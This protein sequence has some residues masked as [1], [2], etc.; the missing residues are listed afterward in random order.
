[1]IKSYIFSIGLAF[2]L[3][4][5][6][7]AQ[8]P[9]SGNEIQN[10]EQQTKT[11]SNYAHYKPN[12]RIKKAL[13][14]FH[15]ATG[16]Y[17][18]D[19]WEIR[20]GEK[21]V[22]VFLQEPQSQIDVIA[23]TPEMTPTKLDLPA[24]YHYGAMFGTRFTTIAYW[25]EFKISGDKHEFHFVGGGD[26]LT[27]V[28]SQ[29]WLPEGKYKCKAKSVHR[30][31]LR[32]DP[33]FGYV[34]DINCTFETDK[35]VKGGIEFTNLL[36]P[37]QSNPW[38]EK[39]KY[40]YTI[41]SSADTS[42]YVRFSSNLAAG[43]LSDEIQHNWGKG[44]T[45]R[46]GGLM[47][48]V[49]KGKYSPALLRTGNAKYVQ[50]TCNVWLDQHNKALL[51]EKPDADGIYRVNPRFRFVY[52]PPQMANYLIENSV[53]FKL[54]KDS[55]VQIRLGVDEGFEEQPLS[56]STTIR[57]ICKGWWEKDFVIDQSLAHRGKKS[58]RIDG[59][60]E[61]Q[62]HQKY[63]NFIIT[64]QILLDPN[65]TYKI[66][67]YVSTSGNVKAFISADLYEWTPHDEARLKKQKT[68]MAD[69]Q[70]KWE[71]IEIVF[72]TPNYDPFVDLRFMV[73]GDGFANF[74]D[75]SFKKIQP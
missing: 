11:Q 34:F 64:P 6:V 30:A 35:F 36:T 12:F 19:F 37:A 50:N 65:S 42:G 33:V 60:T 21:I 66:E 32:I 20:D 55:M 41:Y 51:P 67:A 62:S 14:K 23:P 40:D 49:D 71:K 28:E 8:N 38:P 15:G 31:T 46:N 7:G 22:A 54:K 2:L 74:D 44:T 72:K 69:Q 26:S 56:T 10:L 48:F 13:Y 63:A 59:I 29:E 45:T 39:W 1:M 3:V 24:R 17:Q 47:A 52:L 16:D 18:N 61:E 5:N 9:A 4:H 27:I 73:I 43:D 58:I 57:G 75:F 53:P 70:G 25:P 68:N